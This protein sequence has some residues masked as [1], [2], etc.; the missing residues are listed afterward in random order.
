[1]VKHWTLLFVLLGL[2]GLAQAQDSVY[3]GGQWRPVGGSPGAFLKPTRGSYQPAQLL[4]TLRRPLNAAQRRALAEQGIVELAYYSGRTYRAI[5]STKAASARV[6]PGVEAV[7]VVQPS[8]KLTQRLVRYVEN[9]PNSRVEVRLFTLGVVPRS[10]VEQLVSSLGGTLQCYQGKGSN[11]VVALP[12]AV[13]VHLA[14]P[15]RP[16]ASGSIA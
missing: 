6:L 13:L 12:A 5:D 9:A 3:I 2:F 10:T 7:C 8:W 1:M 16:A 14:A 11:I 15:A 4:L